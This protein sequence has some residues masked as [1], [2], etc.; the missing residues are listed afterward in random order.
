MYEIGERLG[1][2]G[3][4]EVFKYHHKL[5]DIDFAIKILNPAFVS[6]EEREE[7]NRRFFREARILFQLDHGNIVKIYDTGIIEGKPFIRMEYLE[8]YN[9]NEFIKKYSIVNFDRSKKPIIALLE[10]LSYAHSK[11][12]IHRDLKPTNFMVTL[13]GDFK[14]ID[15]GISAYLETEKYTILT[16]TGEK[17][18]GGLF[19]DPY[20][21]QN[22]R[23]RDVRNDIYSV[24]A[25]WY[26]LL[27]G[28]AP[29]GSDMKEVLMKTT[30]ISELQVNVIMK[31]LS[32]DI[33]KR[34][35]SCKEILSILK[36][37]ES[38]SI[39][40]NVDTISIS[41]P[42]I[43]EVTRGYIIEFLRDSFEE[44]ME[45]YVWNLPN[46]YVDHSKVFKYY[47]RKTEVEFLKRLYKLSEMP[48]RD[49]RVKN[50]EEE[51]YLHT[52]ANDDYEM[53]WFFHDDRFKLDDNEKFLKLLC[54]MFHPAVRNEKNDWISILQGINDYLESDGYEIYESGR[55]SNR[56]VYSYRSKI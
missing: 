12:V 23:L 43:T 2:G 5:L 10:G 11:G 41:D 56:S 52:I 45:A 44:Q 25:I 20:L 13:K 15:F 28:R 50:F 9:M 22:P 54:E 37:V 6:E 49:K 51:I 33:D 53:F 4:G 46:N 14:I 1:F 30:N 34:Y 39:H 26:F 42:Q 17:I 48:S 32:Q 27:T 3:F 21:I 19:T 55:V 35:V 7:Y 36:P 31:C 29:S 18:A 47:G 24:G 8:G 38:L 16:R 40:N